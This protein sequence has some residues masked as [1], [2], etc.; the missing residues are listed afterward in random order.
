MMIMDKLEQ[1]KKA[2][3]DLIVVTLIA[4]DQ[5]G[6]IGLPLVPNL[7]VDASKFAPMMIEAGIEPTISKHSDEYPYIVYYNIDGLTFFWIGNDDDLKK[8][9]LYERRPNI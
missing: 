1:I 9:G 5:F 2:A 3:S 4:R 6:F 8:Y 7:Q